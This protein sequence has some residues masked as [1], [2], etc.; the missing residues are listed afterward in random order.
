MI[1]N[2]P[3]LLFAVRN[4]AD[5]VQ[6]ITAEVALANLTATIV[7]RN[8]LL[9]ISLYHAFNYIPCW[10]FQCHRM[11]HSIGGLHVGA[12]VATFI[13]ILLYMSNMYS[14]DVFSGTAEDW[15]L[16]VTVAIIALCLLLMIVTA[17]R[18]VRVRY[19]NVWEYTHRFVGWFSLAILVVHVVTKA[20]IQPV[21][22][23]IFSTP[24]P[25]LTFICLI[26][27]F[28]VWF[29]IRKVKVQTITGNGIAIIKFPGKPTMK[30]GTVAR[31]SKNCLQ[32]HA[33][34]IAMTNQSEFGVIIAGTGD[35]T[36]SLVHS[37]AEGLG[38]QK[39]W[40]RGVNP[41]G[42]MKMHRKILKFLTDFRCLLSR[43]YTCN[44]SRNRPMHFPNYQ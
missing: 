35:W 14:K 4:F 37:V 34:S 2:L 18:P 5:G 19:H 8:E 1:I 32:W 11:L 12:G 42:F 21:P 31:I 39:M 41:P 26:S 20:F 28:Y 15:I 38:P 25:Y 33:F 43:C 36:Q 13:W 24:L 22:L 44:R 29:T 30:D 3:A 17:L 23:A 9:L 10:K 40:I 16:F 7:V 6:K 27:V